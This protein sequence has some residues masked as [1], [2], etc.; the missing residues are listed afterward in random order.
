MDFL[1]N[2]NNNKEMF[3]IFQAESEE[4]LE[5]LFN[6]IY[7]IEK[8][9]SDKEL[10]AAIYRDLH[11]IKGAVRM[12]GFNNIQS[13]FH[14]MEDIFDA[15]NNDRFQLDKNT[16]NLLSHSLEAASKYLQESVRNSREI[17]DEKF[18]ATISSLEYILDIEINEQSNEPFDLQ[19]DIIS[20]IAEIA[21]GNNIQST[22]AEHQEEINQAFNNCFEIIDGIVP[23]EETQDIVILKE[24]VQKIHGF[25]IE[26]NLYEVR[27]SL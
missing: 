4:I 5:R 6:N 22:V 18:T 9:P 26:S 1:G 10:V 2:D 15:V 25:F 7:E 13:I 12:V 23:E 3:T 19:N 21:E 27:T 24:E 17:I 16:I 11:S 8:N 14:K 20:S